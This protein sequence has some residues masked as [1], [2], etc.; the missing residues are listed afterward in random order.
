MAPDG[1]WDA[2]GPERVVSP[3]E[4]LVADLWGGGFLVG[5]MERVERDA[6]VVRWRR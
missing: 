5:K 6:V 4:A 3:G 2:G 1:F